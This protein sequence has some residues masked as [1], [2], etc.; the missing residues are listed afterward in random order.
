MLA[1]PLMTTN[2]AA[3]NRALA[4]IAPVTDHIY[5]RRFYGGDLRQHPKVWAGDG[6]SIGRETN[7]RP[8]LG[9]LIEQGRARGGIWPLANVQL[10]GPTTFLDRLRAGRVILPSAQPRTGN[11]PIFSTTRCSADRIR[12]AK[13]WAGHDTGSN[14]T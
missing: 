12:L 10:R 6:S 14:F 2:L 8:T 9:G 4:E 3:L 1:T 11:F 5:R 7:N 13:I